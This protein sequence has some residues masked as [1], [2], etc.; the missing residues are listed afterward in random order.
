MDQTWG[1]KLGVLSK[2]WLW[3]IPVYML[4]KKF[5]LHPISKITI[6]VWIFNLNHMF[7]KLIIYF[8]VAYSINYIMNII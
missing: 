7:R 1:P 4:S 3:Y 5:H 8:I 2:Q 6:S